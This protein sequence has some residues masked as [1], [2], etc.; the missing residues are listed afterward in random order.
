MTTLAATRVVLIRHGETAWNADTRIQGQ[1]DIALNER[2]R[3]QAARMA[4]ALA[5][6]G[7]E[8]IVSSD[9]QRARATA[10]ALADVTGLP[11]QL[12][13]GLRERRFGCFEGRTFQE[14]DTTWPQEALRWRQRD[15]EWA[16]AEGGESL[17]VFYARCV[18]ASEA[19]LSAHAGRVV[20]LVAHGGVLDCL[21]RAATR[22]HLQAPRSWQLGNATVNRLLHGSEGFTLV[23]WNDARHLDD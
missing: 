13:P 12:D 7:I 20:A 10:Q 6:E 9:L 14:V 5:D 23:G 17:L 16:P 1:L 3:W 8:V 22:Q 15:P 4:D 2:G 19:V 18:A 21:Y 11:L